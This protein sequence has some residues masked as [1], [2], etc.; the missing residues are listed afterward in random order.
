MG[1]NIFP[2]GTL[3][4][5]ECWHVDSMAH[6]HWLVKVCLSNVLNRPKYNT[7]KKRETETKENKTK[8]HKGTQ[9]LYIGVHIP[10]V[11]SERSIQ[12]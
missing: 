9:L 11:F 1:I 3:V 6:S 5:E 12:S 4:V 8:K 7:Q 10:R 2:M